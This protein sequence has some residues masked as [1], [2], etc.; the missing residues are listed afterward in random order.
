MSDCHEIP[1]AAVEKLKGVDVMVLNCLRERPHPTHL[2]LAA[3]LAYLARIAPSR[4]Y[5]IHMCH[6]FTHEEWR[7]KLA[8]TNVEPAFDGLELTL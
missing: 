1:D 4:A 3:A 8:G 5:L 2:S 6:D 7:R